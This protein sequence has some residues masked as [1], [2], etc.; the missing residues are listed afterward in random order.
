[1]YKLKKINLR[2]KIYR[3][4]KIGN[5]ISCL[6]LYYVGQECDFK[7]KTEFNQFVNNLQII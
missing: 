7:I 4:R 6:P 3:L 1:M 5:Y 2:F